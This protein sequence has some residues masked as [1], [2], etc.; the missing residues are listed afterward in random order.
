LEYCTIAGEALN[1]DVFNKCMMETVLSSW[2]GF[3][4][5][6]TTV[7]IANLWNRAENRS[8]VSPVPHYNIDLIDEEGNSVP[9]VVTGEIVIPNRKKSRSAC[10]N[11][12]IVTMPKTARHGTEKFTT[13][14]TLAWKD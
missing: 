1:P 6:E 11:A 7:T 8:W 9:P 13:R 5:T 12:I 3:G 2:K 4:Q 10:L 14:E